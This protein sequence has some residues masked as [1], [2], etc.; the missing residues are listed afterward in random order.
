MTV[1]PATIDPQL[2]QTTREYV[3]LGW[4]VESVLPGQVVLVSGKRVNHILHLLLTVL[5]LGLW[6]IPWMIISMAGGEKRKIITIGP[7]GQPIVRKH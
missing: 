2:E 3:A 7:D 1:Q 4:R 5:T 6:L